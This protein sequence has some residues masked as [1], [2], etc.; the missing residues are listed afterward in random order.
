MHPSKVQFAQGVAETLTSLGDVAGCDIPELAQALCADIRTTQEVRHEVPETRITTS[1]LYGGNRERA[2]TLIEV[3]VYIAGDAHAKREYVLKAPHHFSEPS[4]ALRASKLSLG[5]KVLLANA[6]IIL[7][8]KLPGALSWQVLQC[9]KAAL[10]PQQL[11]QAMLRQYETMPANDVVDA[12]DSLPEHLFV[13]GL[14]ES[15]EL[16]WTD[17]G[18]PRVLAKPCGQPDWRTVEHF[19]ALVGL[20]YSVR[21]GPEVFAH[22]WR[23]ATA[24]EGPLTKSF[25]LGLLSE[26]RAIATGPPSTLTERALRPRWVRFYEEV[27]RLLAD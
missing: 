16:R 1:T 21:A 17:R 14:P 18:K 27:D 15:T 4:I 25:M 11:G 12:F 6:S 3:V 23:A 2:I 13:L 22:A 10:P 24:W 19:R 8:E 7:E 5:P 9:E 26:A 20:L